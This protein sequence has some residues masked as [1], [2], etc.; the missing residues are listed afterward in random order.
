MKTRVRDLKDIDLHSI[1]PAHCSASLLWL[2]N[3]SRKE[4]WGLSEAE[5]CELLGGWSIEI[6]RQ[7][8]SL[9]LS[10]NLVALD[11]DRI[12]RLSLLLKFHKL[13]DSLSPQTMDASVLF[14]RVNSGYFLKGAS[15][16]EYL[17]KDASLERFL[18]LIDY[19]ETAIA[20]RYS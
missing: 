15:I 14:N 9:S 7:M 12:I 17:L 10:G 5:Q 11:E 4:K 1:T 20:D 8:I 6:Y 19:L 3:I 2:S 13:L 18:A 16:R